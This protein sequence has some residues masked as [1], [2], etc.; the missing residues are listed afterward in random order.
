[1]III[2]HSILVYFT[3]SYFQGKQRC[4]GSNDL[5]KGR[6]VLYGEKGLNNPSPNSRR[7]TSFCICKL[8]LSSGFSRYVL[9]RAFPYQYWQF[10]FTCL[11]AVMTISLV[12]IWASARSW[13]CFMASCSLWSW[14]LSLRL[15][16]HSQPQVNHPLCLSLLQPQNTHPS[17]LQLITASKHSSSL[18]ELITASKPSSY[19]FQLIM[20]P[21]NAHLCMNSFK[22]RL[23]IL[24]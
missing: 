8:N 23:F 7:Q 22:P 2:I 15:Y 5:W 4:K 3:F 19:M 24:L 1:M 14:A 21:Q 11:R 9:A 10:Y 16:W 6:Q 13:C 12:V 18:F 17:L 20:E